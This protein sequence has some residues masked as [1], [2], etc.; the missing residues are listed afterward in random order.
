[1]IARLQALPG[2]NSDKAKKSADIAIKFLSP[3]QNPVELAEAHIVQGNLL[4][5]GPERAAHYDKAVAL[6]PTD[7]R[8]RRT[9]GLFRLLR[10]EFGPA[11]KDFIAALKQDPNESGVY[12]ALGMSYMMDNELDDNE[13]LEEAKKAFDK[14]INSARFGKHRDGDGKTMRFYY[15]TNDDVWK[16]VILGF[17]L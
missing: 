2:G 4:K 16:E 15:K 8:F 13:R 5:N 17:K 7:T 10:N 11:R 14:A 12:E 6:A 9:R 1:M 3:D